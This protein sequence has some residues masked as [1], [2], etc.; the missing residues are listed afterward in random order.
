MTTS[1]ESLSQSYLH[2]LLSTSS[3]HFHHVNR[4]ER[5]KKKESMQDA[6]I[7]IDLFLFWTIKSIHRFC[8]AMHFRSVIPHHLSHWFMWKISF[9]VWLDDK[10]RLN[11]IHMVVMK[12]YIQKR[13][14]FSSRTIGNEMWWCILLIKRIDKNNSTWNSREKYFKVCQS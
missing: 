13:N 6:S 1:K 11:R 14:W 2:L 9:V 3:R 4:R 8:Q 5:E 10:N 7:V 12:I